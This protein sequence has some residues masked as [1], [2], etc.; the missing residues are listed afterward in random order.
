MNDALTAR[1]RECIE[2]V[3]R[4]G[5]EKAAALAL[6]ISVHTLRSHLAN[7]RAKAGVTKT[8]MLFAA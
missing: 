8:W 6:G 4:H 2:A 5:S 7:A 3:H 1:E